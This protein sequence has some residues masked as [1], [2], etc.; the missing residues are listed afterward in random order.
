MAVGSI[1]KLLQGTEFFRMLLDDVVIFL[2]RLIV[3]FAVCFPFA[4]V[5]LCAGFD[6]EVFGSDIHGD[7]DFLV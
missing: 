2:V 5:H 6:A 4:E 7:S 3:V 1:V